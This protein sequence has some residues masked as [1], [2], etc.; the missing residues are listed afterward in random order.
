MHY[1]CIEVIGK[2]NS[3]NFEVLIMFLNKSKEDETEWKKDFYIFL[4]SLSSPEAWAL[5]SYP[6]VLWL[7]FD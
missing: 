7:K 6:F 2:I 4:L 1:N 3:V 5:N